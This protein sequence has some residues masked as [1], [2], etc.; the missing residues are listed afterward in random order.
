LAYQYRLQRLIAPGTSLPGADKEILSKI[1]ER[2]LW[3]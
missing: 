1:T 3:K 2:H